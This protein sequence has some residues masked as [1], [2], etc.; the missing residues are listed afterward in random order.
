MDRATHCTVFHQYKSYEAKPKVDT[1]V[2]EI[3]LNCLRSTS[4][5][6]TGDPIFCKRCEALLNASSVLTRSDTCLKW[7][8]EF[9]F[10]E[11]ELNI[12]EEEVPKAL[13]LTY[14]LEGPQTASGNEHRPE[15]NS[16]DTSAI[17]FC[18][19][20]SGSM[21]CSKQVSGM[22][23]LRTRRNQVT[24]G[25]FTNVTRL[26]C[27]QAAVES[28]LKSIFESTPNKK[29]GLVSFSSYVEIIGD[30]HYKE[31]IPHNALSDF[32][33]TIG[34]IQEKRGAFL[35]ESISATRDRLSDTLMSLNASGGTAL[36]PALLSSIMM[37]GEGGPGSKVVI[38][39]DGLANEG[40]GSLSGNSDQD[41][42]YNEVASIAQ[43][44]GVSVSVITIEGAECR[45]ESLSLV[46]ETTG[47]SI[48]K[49]A[50]ETL[51]TEFA[52]IMSD[53]VIATQV[54]VQVFLNQAV[55]FDTENPE[56]LSLNDSRMNKFV[57]NATPSS[58]FSFHYT[59]KT[60]QEIIALGIVKENIKSIPF[61]ALFRFQSLDGKKCM[62]AITKSSPVS[63]NKA[64]VQQEVDVEILARAGR[65]KAVQLAEEGK[66]EEAKQNAD[67]WTSLLKEEVKDEHQA[68]K[69]LEF[70][71]DVQE[72]AQ[73]I[74]QQL[75]K[76]EEQG[77]NA[78]GL[79]EEEKAK[80]KKNYGDSLIV[81]MSKIKKKK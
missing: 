77:M 73:N 26:E 49:V 28:Q 30:G 4:S 53:D 79:T 24:Q 32:A 52:N 48:V 70:E 75:K 46:T 22:F 60:D 57:G 36:G 76:E 61:Q 78:E 65:R 18:V 47:G 80:R 55:R 25:N 43:G 9:C 71:N 12:D 37:A 34:F 16:G 31:K 58:S 11:N 69:L 33:K 15:S 67:M 42:F 8:C 1:N 64:E 39:T 6:A 54:S 41:G 2:I 40:I 17:V 81:G 13:E 72:L 56:H 27:V 10:Y 21:A 5:L 66:L 59:I 45:L 35:T 50:P 20:V 14:Y 7:V 74:D 29:V 51:T 3:N 62:R 19:D 44:M 23:Q 38:C 68:G 63:F